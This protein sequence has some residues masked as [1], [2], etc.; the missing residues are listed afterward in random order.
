MSFDYATT[1]EL[2][3]MMIQEQLRKSESKDD[4]VLNIPIIMGPVGIG[5]TSLFRQ[6]ADEYGLRMLRINCGDN[7][8]PTDISGMPV[9]S[10]MT[11][12]KDGK[13]GYMKRSTKRC[14]RRARS[15]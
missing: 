10:M 15:P 1:L 8:D 13:D 5:K 2:T 6:I 11:K 12:T 9:P 3:R 7:S 14:G 4:E